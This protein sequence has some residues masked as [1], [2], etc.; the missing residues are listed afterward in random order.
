MAK[1]DFRLV[2][3][4][5][6]F[7]FVFASA[8]D[9]A[10]SGP[11]MS[12]SVTRGSDGS[13]VGTLHG[14]GPLMSFQYST[15]CQIGSEEQVPCFEFSGAGPSL[16]S[17]PASM[18]VSGC[19]RGI[20]PTPGLVRCP[21]AGVKSI[22]LV[23]ESGGQVFVGSESGGPCSPVPVTVEAQ[24][25]GDSPANVNVKDRCA[26]TVSCPGQGF[27][28]VNGDDS[29]TVKSNCSVIAKPSGTKF[30]IPH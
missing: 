3:T 9:G 6:I 11:G 8:A 19:P 20:A 10:G 1:R 7:L 14:G 24:S 12:V 16:G 15:N 27:S 5:A 17:A 25:T 28:E 4:A 2:L 26:E 18:P 22:E 21:T 23:V 29:D 13:L 30:N